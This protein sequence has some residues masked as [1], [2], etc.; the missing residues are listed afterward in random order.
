MVNKYKISEYCDVM[1]N[2]DVSLVCHVGNGSVL[3]IPTE[4]WRVISQ[5]LGEYSIE[6]ICDATADED[7]KTYM[8]QI[9][10][11]LI[12]KKILIE[13]SESE[14]KSVDLAL[15][16]RCNLRCIHCC[17]DSDLIT[18]EDSLT[19]DEWKKII[20][21]VVDLNPKNIVISGGEPMVRQDFFEI[22]MY[23]KEKH[24]GSIDLM[25]NGLFITPQNVKKLVDI[26][27][28]FNIS[29]D[30]Y[31]EETCSKIRGKGVF[32]KVMDAV[33]LLKNNDIPSKRIALSMVETTYTRNKT[34]LF[35]ELNDRLGT[36]SVVRVFSPI[37]RGEVNRAQ[38]E[39]IENQV[40]ENDVKETELP[41]CQSCLA[42]RQK[43]SINSNGDIYPCMLLEKDEYCLGNINDIQNLRDFFFEKE[44]RKTRGFLNMEKLMPQK[45]KECEDCN[46]RAFCV[47]C[48][49]DFEKY[50]NRSDF[51]KLCAIQKKSLQYI[52]EI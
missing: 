39:I 30:G 9:F 27:S 13:G 8:R 19:T 29:L 7:D 46:V 28:G 37:G 36:I 40:N 45:K 49:P 21:K 48:F 31:D 23:L 24:H 51:S 6:E 5:Y 17:V 38:L 14:I 41:A 16:N 10:E 4:C 1:V 3:K 35:D 50:A 18:T 47:H 32:Q 52:W 25:T 11:A 12:N 2:G 15:T 22:V 20:D 42:G 43:F 44:C 34:Q 33:E 26:F